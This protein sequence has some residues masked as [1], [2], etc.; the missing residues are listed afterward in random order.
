LLAPQDF[1][2]RLRDT[3]DGRLRVRWSAAAQEF[4]IEQKVGRASVAPC[5]IDEGRDDLIRA[6]DGFHPVMSIRA[7]DRMPCPKCE[8]ELKVPIRDT[9]DLRCPY[10]EMR[11]AQT[12]LVVGFWP[13]DDSLI[14]HLRKIDPLRDDQGEQA[15]RADHHNRLLLQ[16]Q[17]NSMSD[18]VT[19]AASDDYRRLVG[20]PMVGYTGKELL[21]ADD[22][23]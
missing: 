2:D 21:A 17:E 22:A 6:R 12:R 13:L 1:V 16:S 14:E 18:A 7:G 23:A 3:F 10:C 15:A 9:V 8:Y 11:G 20:I 5:R 19:S 4:Q